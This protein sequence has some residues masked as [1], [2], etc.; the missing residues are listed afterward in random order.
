MRRAPL[1]AVSNAPPSICLPVQKSCNADRHCHIL[2]DLLRIRRT[3]EPHTAAHG[4]LGEAIK[5]ATQS[6]RDGWFGD[7]SANIRAAA[8]TVDETIARQL[9]EVASRLNSDVAIRSDA[10]TPGRVGDQVL[11]GMLCAMLL[12]DPTNTINRVTNG[13]ASLLDAAATSLADAMIN[14]LVDCQGRPQLRQHLVGFMQM[15][16]LGT[17]PLPPGR[18]SIVDTLRSAIG[19]CDRFDAARAEKRLRT[20][21]L[22]PNLVDVRAVPGR[23]INE[24]HW[25]TQLCPVPSTPERMAGILTWVPFSTSIRPNEATE[26]PVP[27]PCGNTPQ[28]VEHSRIS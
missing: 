16:S 20:P 3:I 7:A 17:T 2:I 11:A 4:L 9:E 27:L 1:Q 25:Q 6:I 5:S 28:E 13:A 12:S 15:F 22:A 21:P 18:I 26:W 14:S 24:H 23:E 10:V 8:A 19:E